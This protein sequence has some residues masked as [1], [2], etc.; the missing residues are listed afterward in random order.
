MRGLL[1][2]S[3]LLFLHCQAE[4]EQKRFLAVGFFLRRSQ[5]FMGMPPVIS[6]NAELTALKM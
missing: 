1:T 6:K 2:R 4:V 5:S 3:G